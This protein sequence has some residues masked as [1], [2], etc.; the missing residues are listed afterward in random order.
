[1]QHPLTHN[2]RL[3]GFYVL[4]WAIIGTI[5]LVLQVFWNNVPFIFSLLDTT[6]T[7]V[8]YPLLGSSIWYSIRYNSLEEVG[9]IRLVLFHFIA[10]SILCGIWVYITYAIYQLFITEENDFLNQGIPTKIFYGYIIDTIYLVFFDTFNIYKNP[11][12]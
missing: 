2:Y 11:R 3:L 5:N 10:A 12:P 9:I 8:L 4:F 6:T 1:M 7:Y